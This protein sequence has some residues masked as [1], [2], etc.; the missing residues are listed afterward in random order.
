MRKCRCIFDPD[1]MYRDNQN[2]GRIFKALAVAGVLCAMPSDMFAAEVSDSIVSLQEVSVTAIKS[3][4]PM[5]LRPMA[6]TTVDATRIE[7]LNIVTMKEV[8]EIAPN[9]Y[10]PEYGSR[11]TSSI[12]VRGL[13]ARIDQPVVGLNVDNVPFLNKD[14]YDFDLTDIERIEVLRGPQS[15]LYGR[16]TMGGMVNIYTLSPMRYQGLRAMAEY[17]SANA[18]RV[19]TGYYFRIARSAGMAVSAS[20]GRSDGYF[21][22]LYNGS[23]TDDAQQGCLRWKSVWRISDRVMAENTASL[24]LNR[25]SGYPYEKVGSQGVNYN[26]TCFYKRTGVADGLTVRWVGGNVELSSITSFQYLSDNMTLDQDFT[27]A[28]YFTLTQ[29]R[30]EWAVTQDFVAKGRGGSR[31]RWMC[32]LFGF[33]KRSRM[34]APVTFKSDGISQLI[35]RHRNEANPLYPVKWD[36]DSF[37]LGSRFTLPVRG[38]AL[39]HQSTVDLGRWSVAAGLRLD[40]EQTRLGY[41]SDCLTGYTTYNLTGVSPEVFDRRLVNIDDIGRLSKTFVEFLPKVSVSYRLPMRSASTV[42]ASVAKGY[43]AGGFNTQMFSDVLQQRVMGLMGLSMEYNI[44]QVV[45]Y[46]P[47]QSWNYEIGAHVECAGGRVTTDLAVFYIDC[48]DQQMTTFPD[49]TTTGRIMTN[50]GRTRSA[51]AEVQIGWRPVG[52]W[53]FNASYG[54]TDARFVRFDDGRHD[55]AGNHIPYAPQNTVF[56]GVSYKQPLPVKWAECVSFDANLRGVGTIWWDEA[57]TVRQP[58]Y[59]QVGASIKV[60]HERYSIDFWGE[61]I[62]NTRYSTFY[63]VSMGN[64]FLQKGKPRRFGVTVRFNFRTA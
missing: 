14:N 42:Y 46:K 58:F 37:V 35:E 51:G 17:G 36:D 50:A 11:M 60:E 53:I 41:R 29:R 1:M 2:K 44:D 24:Q 27:A 28:D 43:K 3:T 8:S 26:D 33:Y 40:V 21:R 16:N 32:G 63:F 45:G 48:R 5:A 52:R 22:N 31:Y 64:A 10:I 18:L 15:T 4:A 54:F 9:F 56:A 49:G 12:Y 20:Y 47:E 38:A 13:G 39:Y 6:S 55:Y 59:A 30:H 25:Q 23:R 34:D 19:S 62:L 61:N 7:R 57:N